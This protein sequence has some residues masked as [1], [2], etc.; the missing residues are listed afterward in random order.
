[1]TLLFVLHYRADIDPVCPLPASNQIFCNI[2]YSR[3]ISNNL[4]GAFQWLP[5]S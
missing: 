4:V 3:E 1:M 2:E 5:A